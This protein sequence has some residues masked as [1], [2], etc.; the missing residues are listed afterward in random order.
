MQRFLIQAKEEYY[1]L[2]LMELAHI[3]HVLVADT[4]GHEALLLE[5]IPAVF[6][7]LKN[8]PD[9]GDGPLRAASDG[10]DGLC[11]QG[12]LD[13]AQA[14]AARKAVI[15]LPHHLRLLRDDPGLAVLA[16]LEGVQSLVLD[17]ALPSR[18]AWRLPH[19]TFSLMDSLSPWATAPSRVSSSSPSVSRVLMFC[20]SKMMAM[21][22]S[23]RART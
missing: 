20:S 8:A 2:F 7:V 3:A 22:S 23:R 21:P 11:F 6:L 9:D 10:G 5:D 1:E 17:A 16:L 14:V 13:H 12:V 4:V 15:D 18:M 19:F